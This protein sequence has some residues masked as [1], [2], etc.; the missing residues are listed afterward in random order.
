M[1]PPWMPKNIQ[2]R[3]FR[4]L[5]S[6]LSF[7][8]S[9]DL[10]NLEVSLGSSS[11][12]SLTDVEL[13][14]DKLSQLMT[15][16]FVRHGEIKKV[17]VALSISGVKLTG[18]GIYL[19]VK[20][21]KKSEF[22]DILERTTADL[23]E[24]IVLP[25]D[26]GIGI[27]FSGMVTKIVDTALS[28][29]DVNLKN[30]T[31]K[32]VME[33]EEDEIE[34]EISIQ[35]I[36]FST[37]DD[38]IR[39]LS[40]GEVECSLMEEENSMFK[41]TYEDPEFFSKS[42][43]L[44]KSSH[45]MES[46]VFDHEASMYMSAVAAHTFPRLFWLQSLDLKFKSL[47][48]SDLAVHAT[49]IHASLKN[50]PNV[51]IPLLQIIKSH[52]SPSSSTTALQSSIEQ[53]VE[54]ELENEKSFSL[55]SVIVDQFDLSLNL[56][57][58]EH[59][60]YQDNIRLSLANLQYHDSLSSKKLEISTIKI[61]N[62][63]KPI[64]S[65]ESTVKQND[66][67]CHV[68]DVCKVMIPNSASVN[69]GFKEILELQDVIDSFDPVLKFLSEGKEPKDLSDDDETIMGIIGQTSA[70]E[71]KVALDSSV[72]NMTIFPILLDSNH[73][74]F[75]PQVVI[76]VSGQDS[77]VLKKLSYQYNI[78]Q[79]HIMSV[80]CQAKL[81]QL[82]SLNEELNSLLISRSRSQQKVKPIASQPKKINFDRILLEIKIAY[83]GVQLDFPGKLRRIDF[84]L[85][86]FNTK[87][88]K[89]GKTNLTLGNLHVVRDMRDIEPT[90]GHLSLVRKVNDKKVCLY[91]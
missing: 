68:S 62:G 17:E 9:I 75:C 79:L 33:D 37:G 90:I 51:L 13:D 25:E 65:F 72:V 7:F 40:I 3:V 52:I 22:G 64:L 55:A 82:S 60:E 30:I 89:S 21:G 19:I 36:R 80:N 4:Y 28:Q 73:I 84:D 88:K 85:V 10:D 63:D 8:T 56:P 32:V 81:E 11:Q 6:K 44:M 14:T 46:V 69:I 23:A 27:D 49:K 70:F 61:T 53:E 20:I 59:G 12:V 5:L 24:S 91:I 74:V 29:L 26:E 86:D 31:I 48:M 54:T 16:L 87:I 57:L 15:G 78:Q 41:S 18:E 43:D 77:V 34:T 2:K 50:L 45:L 67:T 38:G 83:I 1:A 39:H 58:L 47:K 42:V 35:H 76:Q 71:I 66:F